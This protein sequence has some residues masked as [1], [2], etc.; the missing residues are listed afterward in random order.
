MAVMPSCWLKSMVRI[1]MFRSA[2]T[3]EL[4]I[5]LHALSFVPERVRPQLASKSPFRKGDGVL[6]VDI[7][8]EENRELRGKLAL[9]FYSRAGV[10]PIP[11]P[12]KEVVRKSR[13][14]VCCLGSRHTHVG[15]PRSFP[16]PN[17]QQH[18]N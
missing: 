9:T 5:T 18:R 14:A 17:R 4:A 16:L 12:F 1:E 6:S 11:P 10:L 15:V 7:W 2:S 13:A 3:W 8:K